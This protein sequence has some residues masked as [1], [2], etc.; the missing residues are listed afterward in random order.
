MKDNKVINDF[1]DEWNRF[2]FLDEIELLKLEN[3]FKKYILPLPSNLLLEGALVAADFGAGS[4]RWSHFLKKYCSKLYV[5]EPSEKAFKVCQG[6]FREAKIICLNQSVAEN[7]VPESSLDLA[8]SLGVLHHIP[9]TR[10]AIEQIG[11]KLKEGG[12]FLCYLYY[13][14]E[15][16]PRVYRLIW[17]MSDSIRKITSKLPKPLKFFLAEVVALL[18]YLPLAKLSKLLE[19]Q[20]KSVNKIPLHHYKDL[21]FKVMRNDA[22]DRFGTSLEQRF[23]RSEIMEMLSAS[24]FDIGTLRFS[25]EE[26]FWT[27]AVEKS[28]DGA[29]N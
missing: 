13:A 1:G 22:L 26:P 25:M 21:S 20:G 2:N 17:K 6:R 3:Q 23:T 28:T 9:D 16:K 29:I 10:L 11:K 5:V 14:L 12:V 15:N 24:G 4:G 18:V 27:F 19:K 8:I 7:E